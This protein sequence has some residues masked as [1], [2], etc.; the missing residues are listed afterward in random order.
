MQTAEFLARVV[1]STG[2]YLSVMF[3]TDRK[4]PVVRSYPIASGG[5]REA[6]K[7]IDWA[8]RKNWDI[9]HALATFNLADVRNGH[10]IASREVSN[11]QALRTLV[12][13]AD[14]LAPHS[15]VPARCFADRRAAMAWLLAFCNAIDLPLPNLCVDSG[16]GFHWY[17][18]LEGALTVAAWQPLAHALRAAML[19]HG[20]SGDTA[21]TIDAARILRP[22]GSVNMKSGAA[23][24]VT[25]STSTKFQT[26]DYPVAMLTQALTP[27]LG[28]QTA[29]ATGTGGR[30]ATVHML[31]PKP[32]HVTGQGAG[33]NAN[34]AEGI[35]RRDYKLAQIGLK[36][37]QVGMSLA[38]QGNGDWRDL[39][40]LGHLTLAHFCSDGEAQAH[41]ISRGDPRYTQ[42]GT[43]AARARI[44]TQADAKG[45]GA[46]TCKKYDDYR[47]GVCPGCPLWGRLNSPISLGT[48]DGDLPDRYRRSVSPERI[49]MFSGKGKE[50]AWKLLMLGNVHSPRLDW[51]AGGGHQL[52]FSY[53]MSGTTH[54][55][56]IKGADVGNPMML[57]PLV[58]K[59]GITADRHN[60]GEIGDFVAAWISKLR[61]Q[62]A[63]ITDAAKPW[64]WIFDA[65]GDHAGL[66]IGG[67]YYRRNG[68]TETVPG[69]DPKINANYKPAGEFAKWQQAAA[70]FEQHRPDLQAMIAASFGAPLIAL[71]G[72]I[73]GISM[74]FWSTESGIGKSSAIKV[75]QSVWGNYA[76][77]QSMRDTPNSVMRSLS[78]PRVLIRYWDEMRVDK[79][80]Q[81]DF[82]ELIYTIPS[83]KERARMMQDTTL[84]EQ[85]EWETILLYTSNGSSMDYLWSHDKGTDAGVRR[86]FEV[87]LPKVDTPYDGAASQILKLVENNYGHAGRVYAAYLAAHV[88]E[89]CALLASTKSA[90]TASLGVQQNERFLVTCMACLLVGASLARKLGLFAFDVRGIHECLRQAFLDMRAANSQQSL[91]TPVAGYDI[92]ELLSQ[93]LYENAD[94]KLHTER[95]PGAGRTK[96]DVLVKPRFDVVRFQVAEQ[97]GTLRLQRSLFHEWL[98]DRALPATTVVKQMVADWSAREYRQSI[99]AGTTHAGGQVW[100]VDVP[101][102]GPLATY[103]IASNVT[104][105]PP[106]PAAHARI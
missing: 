13:D 60:T 56:S 42:A 104:P 65:R 9:Y 76:T 7:I 75:G 73:R 27:W 74:N 2:N 32:A 1:P 67:T 34:A 5:V 83:G 28:V 35:E 48:D 71:A 45:F 53:E 66:A 41:E 84:R 3:I 4:I 39:W 96:V 18:V 59:Q 85:G 14:V 17:W 52:T 44:A 78:V 58:E 26:G 70:L 49:E 23:V 69:G 63:Q 89:V 94:Y 38:N 106:K 103:L 86:L 77:M 57:L 88:D 16:F 102:A 30:T 43:D 40:E 99:G 24:P 98:R 64:G 19:A 29:Q 62:R 20:W 95:F 22:P 15:K 61:A 100:V 81:A 105:R 12:I 87:H 51:L 72:D 97:P 6:S 93:Y 90:I 91:I 8:A 21:P 82:V 79:R 37:A 25:V 55:L 92:E 80:W 101:L 54:V 31:G 36:C 33:L 50:A 68:T 46:P 11:A 47:P 10:V